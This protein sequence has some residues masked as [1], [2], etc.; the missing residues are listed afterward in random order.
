MIID[1]S[2]YI[3]S[4]CSVGRHMK[5]LRS[6]PFVCT[7]TKCTYYRKSKF[8]TNSGVGLNISK[9]VSERLLSRLCGL[10]I[11]TEIY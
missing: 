5:C 3:L 10:N 1:I 6:N 2:K 9:R 11:T 7:K 8:A 4:P